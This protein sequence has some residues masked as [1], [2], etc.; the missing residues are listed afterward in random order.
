MELRREIEPDYEIKA[1]KNCKVKEIFCDL[2]R[3]R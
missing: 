1:N 3:S 2:R